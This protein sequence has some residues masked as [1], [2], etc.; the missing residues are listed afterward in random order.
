MS[1]PQPKRRRI[2][3]TDDN[4]NEDET[5]NASNDPLPE[6]NNS[7]DSNPDDEDQVYEEGDFREDED[8]GEDLAENWLA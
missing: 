3:I 1:N 6:D 2:V 4:D 7:V 8:D 5:P